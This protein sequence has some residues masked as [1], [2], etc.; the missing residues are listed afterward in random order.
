[1]KTSTKNI[2][3]ST[4]DYLRPHIMIDMLGDC[5]DKIILDIG[6]GKDPLSKKIDCK[7]V[8]TLDGIKECEP[9][10]LCDLNE[11]IYLH[12]DTVDKVLAGEVIEHVHN[13][14]Q[15]VREI[16][17]VLKPNGEVVI[18]TP[19]IASLKNRFRL[20]FGL[21]PEH[22]CRPMDWWGFKKHI[23]DFTVKYLISILEYN[24]FEII[25]TR[26]NGIIWHGKQL[27]PLAITPTRFGEIMIIK[28]RVIK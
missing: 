26:T 27:L 16:A 24:G 20:M 22:A 13:P 10:I 9:D 3:S 5:K 21:F 17:R 28:A 19:N 2:L 1:M 14:V 15:F 12:N 23:T 4:F 25:E 8:L 6:A 7:R 18:S 11:G